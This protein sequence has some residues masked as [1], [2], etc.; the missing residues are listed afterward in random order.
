MAREVDTVR[1]GLELGSQ[2]QDTDRGRVREVVNTVNPST[3]EGEADCYTVEGGQGSIA[4]S[5]VRR[6]GR[7][8]DC[9]RTNR[10][11]LTEPC[12]ATTPVKS[13]F[14]RWGQEGQA[15]LGG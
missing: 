1:G 3:R 10:K 12:V 9:E 7:E 13:A 15:I 8:E 5:C 4:R 2:I 11:L 6:G 14:E